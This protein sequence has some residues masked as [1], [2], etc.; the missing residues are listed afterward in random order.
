MNGTQKNA[1]IK[2]IRAAKKV[3]KQPEFAP[4]TD[5]ITW[6]HGAAWDELCNAVRAAE[7]FTRLRGRR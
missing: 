6:R 3:M 4:R 5:G 7:K 2:L 1:V